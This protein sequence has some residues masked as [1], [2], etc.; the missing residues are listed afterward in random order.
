MPLS[1]S[2]HPSIPVGLVVLVGLYGLCVGP[3][4]RRFGWGPPVPWEQA[5]A[6]VAAAL[7]LFL[8][9]TGPIH[10]LSDSY[11]F[12]VHMLQHLILT[13]I[14]PPLLLLG[15]PDWLVRR[16]LAPRPLAALARTL[17]S[18]PVAFVIFNGTLALWHLPTFYN[19]T[20][21]RLDIHILEHVLFIVTATVGWWPVLAPAPEY[22]AT[23]VVQLVYL[24]AIPFPMKLV[25]L[26]ITFADTVLYPAYAVAPR[27]WGLAPISDQQIGG[28]L[29]WI[30]AAFVFW[31]A[32]GAHFFRWFAESRAED[33]AQTSVA[34]FTRERAI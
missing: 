6:F 1:W 32:F 22:R 31:V 7:I 23:R 13:L 8:V 25:G 29:M 9:L 21:L 20:L 24:L 5:S 14:V 18:A 26:L 15:T 4:R 33:A 19:S 16:V 10:D 11:L 27:V 30:P 34:Q 3:L 2:I 12:T 28:L 17:G